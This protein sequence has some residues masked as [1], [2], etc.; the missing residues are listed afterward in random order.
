VQFHWD[1]VGKNDEKSSCWIRVSQGWAGKQWGNIFI[2]RI[3]QEVVVSFLEGNPDRPLVTGCVYN[4]TETVPYT[5]PDEQT[6]STLKSNSSKGGG[7]F[8]ELRFEDK[9]GSEEVF[10]QAQKDMNV[11]VL[12]D[13]TITVKSNRSVTVQEKDESL[14]VSQ[15]NRTIKVSTGNETHEV[16]GARSVTVTG[17]VTHTDK[18]DFSRT[19]SGNYSLKVSGNLTIDVSGSVTI[20]AGTS[21]TNQAG[22]TLDNKAG[23]SMTNDAQVTLTN[24]AGASQT[25]DG[26]GMLTLKGGLVKIN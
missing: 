5:L 6:K 9:A 4:A 24:K 26:G 20:K 3:G 12:N 21:M 8:N 25:V 19:V 18:A 11:T 23:T 10:M 15:G 7:G 1:Q 2:P 14:T 16:Q 13:Q 22:T 17:N